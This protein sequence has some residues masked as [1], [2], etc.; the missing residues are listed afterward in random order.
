MQNLRLS[1]EEGENQREGKD[2]SLS[3]LALQSRFRRAILKANYSC[4]RRDVRR[5]KRVQQD[6]RGRG[7][8]GGGQGLRAAQDLPEQER[9]VEAGVRQGGRGRVDEAQRGVGLQHDQGELHASTSNAAV[10]IRFTAN[11]CAL[12][13]DY[14]PNS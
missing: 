9:R 12:E 10:K 8:G 4:E 1:W 6:G 13:F 3:D 11:T 14:G 5:V 2:L 7:E